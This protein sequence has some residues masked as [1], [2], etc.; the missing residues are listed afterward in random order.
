[1]VY[2]ISALVKDMVIMRKVNTNC[3]FKLLFPEG[4]SI[5]IRGYNIY[6]FSIGI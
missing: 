5:L 6:S 2:F 4:S 1:M 3:F